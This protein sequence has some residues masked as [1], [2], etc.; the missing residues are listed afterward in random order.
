LLVDVAEQVAVFGAVEVDA[1][2]QLI[3]DLRKRVPDFM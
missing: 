2:V 1:L 3:D